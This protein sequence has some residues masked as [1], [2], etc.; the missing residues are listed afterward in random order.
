MIRHTID[1]IPTGVCRFSLRHASA[2]MLLNLRVVRMVSSRFG[3]GRQYANF[4]T[5]GAMDFLTKSQSRK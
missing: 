5:I 4:G 2:K 1:S 3:P